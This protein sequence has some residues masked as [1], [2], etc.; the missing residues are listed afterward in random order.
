MIIKNSKHD[1]D[2]RNNAKDVDNEKQLKNR[3]YVNNHS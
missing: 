1:S 2:D 3:V